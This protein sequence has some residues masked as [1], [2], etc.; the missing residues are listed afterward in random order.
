M[1]EG[2]FLIGSPIYMAPQALA[3]NFYSLKG[4]AFAFGVF[5]Y[6]I[7]TRHFPWR[8][9]NKEELIRHYFEKSASQKKIILLPPKIKHYIN[10]LLERNAQNRFSVGQIDFNSFSRAQI[11]LAVEP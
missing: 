7:A 2:K 6:Y 8:G 9:K 11:S 1:I 5:L 10:G 3:D 4:D